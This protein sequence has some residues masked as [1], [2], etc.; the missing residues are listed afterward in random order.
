MI[1][2]YLQKISLTKREKILLIFGISLL[3]FAALSFLVTEVL[4]S[5]TKLE[6]NLQ[7]QKEIEEHLKDVYGRYT[8][9]DTP[10]DSKDFLRNMES[11]IIKLLNKY[12]LRENSSELSPRITSIDNGRFDKKIISLSLKNVRAEDVLKALYEIEYEIKEPRILVES[13][14]SISNKKSPGLYRFNLRL[15]SFAEKKENK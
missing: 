1:L 15:V 10:I 6:Q 7:N 9:L 8:M 11:K 12:N 3:L 5:Y 4:R 14:H 13:Y 2:N